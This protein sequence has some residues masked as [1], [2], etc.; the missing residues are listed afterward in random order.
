M[1]SIANIGRRPVLVTSVEWRLGYFIK[2]R[3][4]QVFDPDPDAQR[5]HSKLSTGDH[6]MY[7]VPIAAFNKEVPG[8]IMGL[9]P[10]EQRFASRSIRLVVNTSEGKPF[11]VKVHPT[12]RD[13]LQKLMRER[14]QG[15]ET[16]GT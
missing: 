7:I 6:V 4:W 11:S 13:H 10:L 2:Q 9:P 15:G 8:H 14:S 1:I 5:P 16:K 12:L 3:L